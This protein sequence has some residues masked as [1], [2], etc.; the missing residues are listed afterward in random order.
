MQ[1]KAIKVTLEE[2]EK[3]TLSSFATLS[4]ATKGRQCPI[5]SDDIRTEFQRDR[6]RITHS[7]AFRALMHKT[8]VFLSPDDSHYRTRLT[9][10]LEVAQIARTISRG[11]L[12]NED[13][14]EAIALGHDLGHT[15]FG[16]DGERVLIKVFD[17]EF[18]HAKQ[19]LRVVDVLEKL[20]LTFEVRDGI[21]NHSGNDQ[22]ST[23][24]GAVVK[25]ADRIAYI[26]H[27]I[28][29]ALRAG[30]MKN[31]DIP[32]H[33][34]EVLGETHGERIA[35]MVHSVLHSNLAKGITMTD[36]VGSATEELR[37]FLFEAVYTNPKAKGEEGKAGKMLETLFWHFSKN[38]NEIPKK[39]HL[40]DPNAS[41]NRLVADYI[42]DLT[43]KSAIA[44][45]EKIFIPQL[46]QNTI[47]E[48]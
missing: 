22:P 18:T 30:I 47:I 8:Q 37:T 21:R 25:F 48:N 1:K 43:D 17:S 26:N 9:H 2:R 40:S 31:D 4:S 28:D 46:W 3:A 13:L 11:L 42:S 32:K 34:R 29:D 6:D 16:H 45:F 35:T 24:E 10:T 39:Y 5:S 15:P 41:V 33:L 19:S 36:E 23:L 14:T 44:L 7:S 12:L 27:D 38:P 20:N